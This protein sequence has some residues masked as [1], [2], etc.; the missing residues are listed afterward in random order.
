[1]QQVLL[2]FLVKILIIYPLRMYKI[3][4]SKGSKICYRKKYFIETI[5]YKLH[6]SN[7]ARTKLPSSYVHN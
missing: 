2:F 4:V 3:F 6:R 5:N 1:M 7:D